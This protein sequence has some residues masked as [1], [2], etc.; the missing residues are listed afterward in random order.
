MATNKKILIV[1]RRD[2]RTDFDTAES[3]ASSLQSQSS[4]LVYKPT[5]LE[6]VGIVYDGKHLHMFDR[7]GEDIRSYDAIFMIGWFKLRKHE[8]IAQAVSLY[9]ERYGVSVLNTEALHN[10]SRGKISQYIRSALSDI[11]T[12]PFVICID[13]EKLPEL[14]EVSKISYPMVVKSVT[15]SRGRDNFLVHSTNELADALAQTPDKAFVVQPFV[16]NEGDFRLLV[17][18][19]KVRLAIQ[20]RAIDDTHLNNTS[21]G[22]QATLVDLKTLPVEMLKDAVTASEMLRREITG[23]D[24]IVDKQSGQH[25]FLEANNMPQ[26][27]TGSFVKEKSEMLNSFFTE[28]IDT[29]SLE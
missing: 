13:N 7:N 23:V 18:G 6:E 11:S 14:V 24:M 26:L 2:E 28:W 12:M 21:L 3:L 20:R 29:K 1:S 22:G 4:T 27:S 17:A 16:S 5:F 10:R 15:G 19:K 9:A 8:E 25:Y